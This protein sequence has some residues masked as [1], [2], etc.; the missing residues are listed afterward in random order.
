MNGIAVYYLWDWITRW[1]RRRF[2]RDPAPRW[3]ESLRF[4]VIYDVD[5]AFYDITVFGKCG[6][7]LLPLAHPRLRTDWTPAAAQAVP[8]LLTTSSLSSTLEF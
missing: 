4:L 1:W 7:L 6:G 3:T 8:A 2:G 5:A